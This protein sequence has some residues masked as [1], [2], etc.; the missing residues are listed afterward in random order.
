M[1]KIIFSALFLT[2]LFVATATHIVGGFVSYTYVAGS[3]S[4]YNIQLKIYRDCN[5]QTPFDGLPDINGTVRTGHIFVYDN[6]SNLIATIDLDAPI[7]TTIDPPIDNPCLTNTSGVCV[8]EGVY[9]TTYTLPSDVQG[10]T[11]AYVRCC[12]NGSIDN[13]LSPGSQGGTHFGIHS[14][15]GYISQQ[16]SEF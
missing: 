3:T 5:S 8:E 12:R 16:Q 10:Y 11:L 7:V 4:T 13:I 14:T 2:Q 9:T 1:K 15:N 6:S